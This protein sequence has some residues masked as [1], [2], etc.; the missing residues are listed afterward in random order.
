[1]EIQLQWRL[2]RDLAVWIN[3][4]EMMEITVW[5]LIW[6]SF[7][8]LNLGY[9]EEDQRPITALL[10]LDQCLIQRLEVG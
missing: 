9:L 3:L 8:K 2:H 7:Y 10:N 5:V 6:E 4:K 1:M